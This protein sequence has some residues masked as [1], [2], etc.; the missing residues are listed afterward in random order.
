M[1]TVLEEQQSYNDVLFSSSF[2]FIRVNNSFIQ[3]IHDSN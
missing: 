1:F 2:G 3:R